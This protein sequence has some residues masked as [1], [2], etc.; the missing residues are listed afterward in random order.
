MATLPM[1]CRF[2]VRVFS[3]K[4]ELPSFVKK[5]LFLTVF[6]RTF[7]LCELHG[8]SGIVGNLLIGIKV[9]SWHNS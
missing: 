2:F 1:V 6:A 9:P 8:I 5:R 3:Q 7:Y 4:V